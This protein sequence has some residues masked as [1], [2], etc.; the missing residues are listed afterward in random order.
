MKSGLTLAMLCIAAPCG[1]QNA[2]APIAAV[3]PGTERGEPNVRRI[4]VED[5]L[6]RIDELRVRGQTQQ[7][8]VTPK[9]AINKPYEI[10][11]GRGGRDAGEGAGGANGAVGKRV[12]NVLKF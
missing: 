2:A 12:W 9:G 7:V 10:I 5:E 6:A 4:V 8:T 1:A 11:V 3:A